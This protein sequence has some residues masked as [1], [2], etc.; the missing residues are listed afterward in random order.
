MSDQ[1]PQVGE[2]QGT[3]QRNRS[4]VEI[5]ASLVPRSGRFPSPTGFDPARW[6][7]GALAYQAQKNT[8]QKTVPLGQALLELGLI[9]WNVL[10]QA[11]LKQSLSLQSALEEANRT[12]EDRVRQRTQDLEKRLVEIRTAAEITQFAISASTRQELFKRIVDLLVER[13]DF[14]LASIFLLDEGLSKCSFSRSG[15][16]SCGWSGGS[17]NQEAWLSDRECSHV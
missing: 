12:L 7:A 4:V 9:D 2:D 8:P 17:R 5:P 1:N 16:K 14:Y 3:E 6:F 15:W 10:D 13:F 11:I